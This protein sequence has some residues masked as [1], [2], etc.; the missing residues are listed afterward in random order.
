MPPAE[1]PM[2]TTGHAVAGALSGAGASTA[3]GPAASD[4]ALSGN[5]PDEGPSRRERSAEDFRLPA[6]FR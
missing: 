3:S 4:A 5:G 1:A 2:P 6:C